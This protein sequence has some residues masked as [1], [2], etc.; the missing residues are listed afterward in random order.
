[1]YSLS[2]RALVYAAAAIIASGLRDI[3]ALEPNEVQSTF[4]KELDTPENGA[5][6]SC[7]AGDNQ[8]HCFQR[9]TP[10]GVPTQGLKRLSYSD[11]F[12]LLS[13][14][15][16]WRRSEAIR[17]LNSSITL[18]YRNRHID[19]V[20]SKSN[21]RYDVRVNGQ[22]V[23]AHSFDWFVWDG[24]LYAIAGFKPLEIVQ[25]SRDD[26]KRTLDCGLFFKGSGT[27]DR[28][29][30]GGTVGYL[31]DGHIIGFGHS[32]SHQQGH[33]HSVFFWQ[34]SM[35][36]R[37]EMYFQIVPMP[38]QLFMCKPISLVSVGSA[39]FLVV[40]ESNAVW[41]RQSPPQRSNKVYTIEGIDLRSASTLRQKPVFDVAFLNDA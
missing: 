8:I 4:Y 32:T 29:F 24:T 11:R 1:M 40:T 17:V 10:A 16:A 28:S 34:L 37:P 41:R 31:N 3:R 26:V 36:P 6:V 33:L 12:D 19:M 22:E 25:C 7:T 14:G 15:D 21:A 18:D 23:L 30:R 9:A 2:L 35:K 39:I 27:V 20:D 5:I 38:D 13:A